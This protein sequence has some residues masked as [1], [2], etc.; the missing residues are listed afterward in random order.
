MNRAMRMAL[1]AALGA[2]VYA[3]CSV[4]AEIW[5]KRE[6]YGDLHVVVSPLATESERH[7]AGQF[8]KYWRRCTSR[9]IEVSDSPTGGD[10]N[11]WIGPDGV[12]EALVDGMDLDAL[13]TDGLWIRTADADNLVIVGGRPRGTLYG[14]YEFF[15]RYLGVRWLDPE[16]THIPEPPDALPTIDYCYVPQ[17]IRRQG[18]YSRGWGGSGFPEFEQV[19]RISEHPKFGMFVHTSFSVLPPDK[20]FHDYPE[21][22]SEIGGERVAP[23]GVE[24]YDLGLMLTKHPDKMTQLCYS[25]PKVA[26]AIVNE[27]VPRMRARPNAR[28]WSVSQM[29]WDGHC[30]CAQCRAID[31]RER[32]PMGS[33]LTCINRVADAI[34]EAFPENYIET[35]AY[36]YTRK[37][38]RHLKPRENVII[39]LCSIE[40]DMSRPLTDRRSDVNRAFYRDLKAWSKI[41][42]NLYFWDYPDSCAYGQFPFPN[43]HVLG[44]NMRLFADHGFT[45]A[46]LCGGTQ[47]REQFGALRGYILAKLMWNPYLDAE[48]LKGEFIA[49]YYG[50][51]GPHIHDYIDLLARTVREKNVFLGIFDRGAWIDYELV[52]QCEGIFQRALE[53]A[54]TPEIEQRVRC[55]Y[56]SLQFAAMIASPAIEIADGRLVVKR[57]ECPTIDEYVGQLHALGFYEFQGLY[58]RKYREQIAQQVGETLAPRRLESTIETLENDATLLWIAPAFYGSIIRWRNK[59][60]KC[61]LLGDIRDYGT[62]GHTHWHTWQDWVIS[63]ES[64]PE[65]PVARTYRVT[66][67]ETDGLTL[68]A[69]LD[70]GLVLER[71][72]RLIPDTPTIEV[73]L[74]VYNPTDVAVAPRV[75]THPEFFTQRPATPEIWAD[76]GAEWIQ[77]NADADPDFKVFGAMVDPEPYTRWAAYLPKKRLSIVNEFDPREPASLLFFY[78][79][80]RDKQHVN[81]ELLMDQRPLEPGGHRRITARYFIKET[82]PRK[83]P[84]ARE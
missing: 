48:A 43:L 71:R 12:P 28:I 42:P 20:Y 24:S 11:V 25:N 75:K 13:G 66:N 2:V 50:E 1:C 72:L 62:P 82:K 84:P 30:Q 55:A 73:R 81:L 57:P 35:L 10:M 51:A 36:Q 19:H 64:P 77:L 60:A 32:S 37:A 16:V 46:F 59:A 18:T 69:T 49:L 26:E 52:K 7:A 9:E 83:I 70:N 76:T 27:L 34:K 40:C 39:S 21:Y 53:A 58:G 15:E 65:H 44:P 74:S 29:D 47:P 5:A 6:T 23:V 14:V 17:I 33:L 41:A 79:A 22:Y 67:R 61:E 38:P 45:G 78:N 4:Q 31:E 3:P 8:Q 63:P 54:Q 68:E 56:A 80:E